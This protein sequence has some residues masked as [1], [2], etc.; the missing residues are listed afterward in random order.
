VI[1]TT[2]DSPQETPKQLFL[3]DK[4]GL[5]TENWIGESPDIDQIKMM[6]DVLGFIE[7]SLSKK[8]TLR[9]A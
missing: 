9:L 5:I 1:S 4:T 8:Q 3:M 7:D 2:L 6:S